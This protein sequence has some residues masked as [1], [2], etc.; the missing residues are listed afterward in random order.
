MRQG[1][2]T[3]DLIIDGVLLVNA[4]ENCHVSWIHSAI[5]PQGNQKELIILSLAVDISV[6]NTKDSQCEIW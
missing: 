2:R 1:Q 6:R 3:E 5:N 4:D